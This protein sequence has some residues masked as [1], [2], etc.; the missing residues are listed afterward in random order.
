MSSRVCSGVASPSTFSTPTPS[1]LLVLLVVCLLGLPLTAQPSSTPYVDLGPTP[2]SGVD[3]VNSHPYGMAVH[4]SQPYLYMA[5]SGTS[6]FYMPPSA[7]NG[8][9][10]VELDMASRTVV[11]TFTV[12]MFPTEIEI[13]A[14]GSELYVVCSTA[15]TLAFVDLATGTVS[16]VPMT[17]ST[18]AAVAFISGVAQSADGSQLFVGSNG[19]D[20]DGS[21]EN[22][23][24]VDRVARTIIRRET[25]AGSTSRFEVLSD[26]RVVLPVGFPGNDFTALPEVRIYNS[27]TVPWTLLSIR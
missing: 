6:D 11:R 5:L 4:P 10:V 18:G 2:L 1:P 20:F 26:G 3:P 15:G 19:G 7:T 16:E 24:V 27:L 9:T 23:I 12:G 21:D 25:L 13:A 22:I 17:D 14:D 8:T